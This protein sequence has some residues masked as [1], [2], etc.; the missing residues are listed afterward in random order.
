MI[1]ITLHTVQNPITVVN[2]W[3]SSRS[4]RDLSMSDKRCCCEAVHMILSIGHSSAACSTQPLRLVSPWA[5]VA[6]LE[7]LHL[8]DMVWIQYF[9]AEIEPQNTSLRQSAFSLMG[10]ACQGEPNFRRLLC[11]TIVNPFRSL[12]C[13]HDTDSD[14]I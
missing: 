12:P 7:L 8:L 13:L 9:N 4:L 10:L 1:L 5:T 14:C 3:N 2:Y 6:A 11:D